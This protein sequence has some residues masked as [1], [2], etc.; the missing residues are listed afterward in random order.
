MN[1]IAVVRIVIVML[2]LLSLAATVYCLWRRE[3]STDQH[4]L[5]QGSASQPTGDAVTQAEGSVHVH[6]DLP[7][8]TGP[9]W[10][11][12]APLTFYGR[13]IDQH[14][15]GVP[16]VT[17]V[18]GVNTAEGTDAV[19]TLT[20]SDGGFELT[21][22][23]GGRASIRELRK[24]GYSDWITQQEVLINTGL[25]PDD[26]GC[27]L[28]TRITYLVWKKSQSL[29]P[30]YA[31]IHTF[32][33]AA[34]GNTHLIDLLRGEVVASDAEAADLQLRIDRG[35]PVGNSPSH[36][37]WSVTLTAVDGGLM[38]PAADQRLFFQAPDDGYV[39][40]LNWHFDATKDSWRDEISDQ[41][42]FIRFR[43]G[44]AYGVIQLKV[45]P[46]YGNRDSGRAFW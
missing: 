35:Q 6:E 13:V 15:H 8:E 5:P 29:D 25:H 11:K 41:R 24:A 26:P 18:A 7:L 10:A 4:V 45:D 31:A 43:G 9:A 46:A 34:D 2:A 19:E 3:P 16:G 1:R 32:R 44:R 30:L 28:D 36:F 39:S 27:S 37:S 12:P 33:F 17:V 23:V 42:L 21:T 38:K 20:D 40:K 22:V 14:D